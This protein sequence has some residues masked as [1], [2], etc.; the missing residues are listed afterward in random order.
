MVRGFQACA[1]I[2]GKRF[3]NVTHFPWAVREVLPAARLT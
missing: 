3:A 1:E 2:L